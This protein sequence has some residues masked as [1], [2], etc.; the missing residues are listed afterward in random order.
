[1]FFMP[2]DN[3]RDQF[4]GP[5]TAALLMIKHRGLLN[6][7]FNAAHP[8]VF[9]DNNAVSANM[10]DI[11]FARDFATTRA[12]M[13]PALDVMSPEEAVLL[14]E[15]FHATAALSPDN[16]MRALDFINNIFQANTILMARI[17]AEAADLE[18]GPRGMHVI[19][20]YADNMAT[21]AAINPIA[22]PT[23]DAV[24]DRY[25][26]YGSYADLNAYA[27]TYGAYGYTDYASY[28]NNDT[29]YG[30]ATGSSPYQAAEAQMLLRE[31]I[32]VRL[33]GAG[34]MG[35]KYKDG[36]QFSD[37]QLEKVAGRAL[38]ELPTL[39]EIKFASSVWASF[40]S[41]P[42]TAVHAAMAKARTLEAYLKGAMSAACKSD[43]TMHK[44]LMKA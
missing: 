35:W 29:A 20:F 37:A 26:F 13:P 32:H 42:E 19:R 36:V 9:A 27:A 11:L 18:A 24:R 16:K 5:I 33:S 22:R 40:G 30:Y 2:S 44:L 21:L 17:H 23:A 34:I 7:V 38:Q 15:A 14:R 31:F 12:N 28:Y 41:N 6:H 10:L 43:K 1:M 4:V 8:G 3:V 39:R 25:G